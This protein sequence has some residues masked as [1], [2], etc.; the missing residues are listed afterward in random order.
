[1]ALTGV[2]GRTASIR[3]LRSRRRVASAFTCTESRRCTRPM[4]TR[5]MLGTI[6]QRRPPY[7]GCTS[8]RKT[9]SEGNATRSLRGCW[10]DVRQLLLGIPGRSFTASRPFQVNGTFQAN[11]SDV[12]YGPCPRT[13]KLRWSNW[14]P[15]ALPEPIKKAESYQTPGLKE[16]ASHVSSEVT[17]C[18]RV[19][20]E[21][22]R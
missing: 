21:H 5:P 11:T 15:R 20:A 3:S 16:C 7:L 19:Q 1:M 4:C 13:W 14:R 9:G 2:L 22:F 6:L 18:W 17:A 12:P 10:A 8:A